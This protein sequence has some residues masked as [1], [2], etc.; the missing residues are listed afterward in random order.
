MNKR[1]S[2]VSQVK[3]SLILYWCV[4]FRQAQFLWLSWNRA[5]PHMTSP[6]KSSW[7]FEKT[8]NEELCASW[9]DTIGKD[10]IETESFICVLNLTLKVNC[11]ALTIQG[12]E[13]RAPWS[14]GGARERQGSGM[15]TWNGTV[16][17]SILQF[18]IGGQKKV[19]RISWARISSPSAWS[20][21]LSG[22]FSCF[23]WC[24]VSGRGKL[25]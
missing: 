20:A 24:L 15:E 3:F 13:T 22:S 17:P 6:P 16:H 4:E 11:L 2:S 21:F 8:A 18:I 14:L 5:T 12:S 10:L 7:R 23:C 19:L 9:E 1:Q 25:L